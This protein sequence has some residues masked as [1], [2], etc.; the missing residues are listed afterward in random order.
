MTDGPADPMDCLRD[1]V[2]RHPDRL[3]VTAPDRQLT[4]AA[5]YDR[6][7]TLATALLRRGAGPGTVT[8]ICLPRCADLV[9]AP[10]AAWHAGSA[11]A[12]LDP[13]H[14]AA[15]L[16]ALA[17][18][19]GAAVLV[20]TGD[21]H[22]L[23]GAIEAIEAI[24]MA[25]MAGMAGVAGAT[26]VTALD[27]AHAGI[28]P[29]PRVPP[30]RARSRGVA[31]VV[32][33]D[34]DARAPCPAGEG[35]GGRRDVRRPA[36]GPLA[37]A[38]AEPRPPVPVHRAHGA[39][40][41]AGRDVR[42]PARG[43]L[44]AAGAVAYVVHTSGSTG[45]PKAVQVSHGNVRHLIA[46]LEN[47]GCLPCAPARVAWLAGLSFDASVQ[48]LLRVC[49]GDTLVVP[50]EATRQDPERL[51]GFLRRARI[52]DLDATPA[53]WELLRPHLVRRLP[54][55][56]P[57]RLHLG[58][59]PVPPAMWADLASLAA[60][61]RVSALNL[62][63]PAECTVDATAAPVTGPA[64]VIGA[65]LPGVRAQV[66]DR[67]LRPVAEGE[68]GELYLA[69]DGVALG[70]AG[71]PGRTAERF[72]AEPGGPA[73]SRMY[74][75]GDLVR[76]CGSGRLAYAG[77]VDDQFKLHGVRI[78]PGEI[79]SV[80][81][82]HPSVA[83]AVV[84]LR[85]DRP[86]DRRVVAHVTAVAGAP[87]PDPRELRAHCADRLPPALVPSAVVVLAA[88][89]TAPGGKVDRSALPAPD[90]TRAGHGGAPAD[91]RETELCRLYADVLGLADVGTD[92]SFF[93]LGGHSLLAMRLIGRIRAELHAEA[94]M[95]DLF[96]APTPAA[97]AGRL[98][99]AAGTRPPLRP[100]P[101]PYP[102]PLSYAQ[103]RLW[104]LDRL[105][106]PGAAYN[107]HVALRFTGPLDRR[108][109]EAALFDVVVRHEVLRTVYPDDEGEPRQ[110]ILDPGAARPPL[111]L[112]ATG[113]DELPG[114]LREQASRPFD[115][116]R[117]PPLR[118]RLFVL[119]A[120]THVLLLVI[121]H[122]ASDGWSMRPL[123]R[124][125]ALAYRARCAGRPPD[126]P[127]LPVQY[128][129]YT[130]W[131]RRLLGEPTDPD[132]LH[133]RQ[134]AYWREELDGLPDRLRLP[135]D[136][137]RSAPQ[138]C[139][140]GAT[141]P[142]DCGPE[143][144]RALLDLA[145]TH[146]CTLF[147]V[148]RAGLSVLLTRLGA[149]HDIP[150]GVAIA[151]RGD[152]AL[153]DLV[154]FFVNTLP[155]RTD[156][157]GDPTFRAL[158]ERVGQSGPAAAAHQDLPF[159]TLV[160]ELNPR[161]T[162]DRQPL[163]QVLLAFQNNAEADWCFGDELTVT[164][165][166]VERD[167]ARFDLALSIGEV[168]TRDGGPGGL[169]GT[170]EYAIDLFEPATA[171]RISALLRRVLESAAAEPDRR[172]AQYDLL[173]EEDG[174][175][176]LTGPAATA[177][178]SFD[179]LFEARARR[180]PSA[181]AV[182]FGRQEVSYGDLN[183]RANQLAHRLIAYGVGPEDV[184]AAAL[185]RSVELIVALLAVL[186]TGAA[187]LPLDVGYPAARIAT[188]LADARPALLLAARRTVLP[189]TAAPTRIDVSEPAGAPGAGPATDPT[190]RDRTTPV[191]PAHLAY[192][193][194]T[195]GSTG[196]PKPVAVTRAG[197]ANLV[198]HQ[199]A[200]LNVRT[201][202]SVL[203]FASPGFDAF[204][205]EAGMALT[206]GATLVLAPARRLLPGPE[207]ARLAA[208]QRISHLTVPPAV[209]GVLP[210]D[211]MRGI[212]TLVVAGEACGA[213]L[214]TAW[215]KDRTLLNGYGPTETTVCATMSGA[216]IPDDGI[217]P[218]GAPVRGTRVTI[219]D[220][221]L[222]P[223]P[224]GVTGEL[225]V[226]G[227]GLARGYRDRPGPTA[228]RFVADPYGPAGARMYRTGDLVRRGAD[229][230]LE[231]VGRADDQVNLRGFRI[232]PGEVEA[233]VAAA[234][235]VAGAAVVLREDQ[236]GDRRIVAYVVPEPPTREA[237][238]TG[239]ERGHLA[240]WRQIH[241]AVYASPRGPEPAPLGED[242][243]GWYDSR[244][245]APIPLKDMREWRD[246]T[247][248]RLRE[249]SPV[250]VL[251]IGVGS[252]LLLARLAPEATEYW[253]LDFSAEAIRRLRG[254]LAG[255]GLPDGRVVLRQQSA[256]ESTGIP[257]GRFDLVVLNSVVQYFPSGDYLARVLDTASRALAPGGRVYVGDV[258][259][260]RLRDRIA[261]RA[262]AD[263]ELLVDPG[264]FTAY[265][266][267]SGRFGTCDVRLKRGR[268]ANE[269]TA[270]RYDVML[271]TGP[272]PA[273]PEPEATLRWGHDLHG[274]DAFFALVRA[275]RPARI[276]VTDL[277]NAR[278][279]GFLRGADRARHDA[280]DPE[281]FAGAGEALGYRV[282]LRWSAESGDTHFDAE[283]SVH[284]GELSGPPVRETG[285]ADLSRH[286]NTPL[287]ADDERR[288]RTSVRR[289]VAAALPDHMV[290]SAVVVLDRFP[291]TPHGK[292]DRAAL[293]PPPTGRPDG[294]AGR[295]R[296]RT[297]RERALCA[298]YAD[299]LGLDDVGTD[300]NFF[301]LGGHSLLATRLV[302]RIRAAFG[303]DL[304]VGTLFD[305]PTV[306]DLAPRL[307][308]AHGTRPPLRRMRRQD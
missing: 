265:A 99:E 282:A 116:V 122:I 59:E 192:V 298:M 164:A 190:D 76:R 107:E 135:V 289:H 241:D 254:Q 297:Q 35:L 154:G 155:L 208:E 198:A 69:G 24:G 64:P 37:G 304:P 87:A 302:S 284:G 240:D 146:R 242:F 79:E 308:G 11:F 189:G 27:P 301:D 180:E 183:T 178:P 185:D 195:S 270:L 173:T 196:T 213:E 101:R 179:A 227:A 53:L 54:G 257:E 236:P 108:A 184:V 285:K 253:G 34:G 163:F 121:H 252:G 63:G 33:A 131:Q 296:P 12:L 143:L 293:P 161:R 239:G 145:R 1:A 150:L 268:D 199:A 170:L 259:N 210:P 48:Q 202:D 216:L 153:D 137:P 152:P 194:Y 120:D 17:A 43:V 30:E 250:R 95:R 191:R 147:T 66:L 71:R 274:T 162:A 61:G 49:R 100:L 243:T 56:A 45:R 40:A 13:A 89:P 38:D 67:R 25:G 167:R 248:R 55:E 169:T 276:T 168:R 129:D 237:G 238:G 23:T 104:F 50:D 166:P 60:D 233:H 39:P 287:T 52:T 139:H 140:R 229:G 82:G 245:G 228:Q 86:G 251:E 175:P 85:E 217:P 118:A 174:P 225:Y 21:G 221:R 299:I 306:A 271:G 124:D 266:A 288:I 84:T 20:T 70:Y 295:H 81:A 68:T 51:A 160:E 277:P 247:V 32:E 133:H 300:E 113:E 278:L 8:G 47:G 181:V 102:L 273:V 172:I 72:V 114:V 18:E 206:A 171:H 279:T 4:F 176:L 97:L 98:T 92:D 200:T 187:L 232:E 65:A 261:G 267:A 91:G 246:A 256:H 112:R 158:L 223:V 249:L 22:R 188:I 224:T 212:G 290:P 7:E 9:A 186:K 123:A 94:D 258:R 138:A 219:L 117:E 197:L 294:A 142:F 109:L 255:L 105:H 222:R 177:S 214:A 148:V 126:R 41:E 204:V 226:G 244:D 132:S 269:L 5:L 15:R 93:D 305:A 10:L 90:Y 46:A 182:R 44:P 209:L 207:L 220:A 2:R 157:S 307:D 80:L 149:G 264:Y 211:T 286:V 57:L 28:A 73:G 235:G 29:E 130:L 83:R 144:H 106:G 16:R 14:P 283:F 115:L 234:D 156:T 151:G 275:R 77:R 193:I 281:Q 231:F 128:A 141:V 42:P 62:Y 88:F 3:A 272:V 303:V 165:Q 292:T 201:T 230:R 263:P 262:G 31:E 96:E 203:Q 36:R 291:L 103:R 159:D 134:L 218:L 125:L 78:E 75:T 74:R 19:A 205:W 111:P 26:V 58:G 215:A 119:D 280:V 110:H 260:L 127:A 136:R 6:V